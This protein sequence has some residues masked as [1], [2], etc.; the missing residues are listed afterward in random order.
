MN[1]AS[2]L[3]ICNEKDK[4]KSP[5]KPKRTT[6]TN[7]HIKKKSTMKKSDK[8]DLKHFHKVYKEDSEINFSMSNIIHNKLIRKPSEWIPKP[9][10]HNSDYNSRH[11]KK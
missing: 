8:Y 1:H 2:T 10:N 5:K 6:M 9:E 3:K 7:G 4:G 11:N